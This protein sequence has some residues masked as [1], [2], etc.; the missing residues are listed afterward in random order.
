MT[1]P[2]QDS[3]KIH[4]LPKLIGVIG[5][6]PNARSLVFAYQPYIDFVGAL[7]QCEPPDVELILSQPTAHAFVIVQLAR[8]T[9]LFRRINVTGDID[10]R[11]YLTA[12]P[13]VAAAINQGHL[14][15][16]RDHYLFQGYLERRAVRLAA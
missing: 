12:H 15:S 6:D 7:T 14:A 13:D 3:V 10:Q 9:D 11:H 5:A 8:L 4:K 2:I 16:A 1:K